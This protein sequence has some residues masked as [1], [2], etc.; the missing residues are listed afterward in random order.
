MNTNFLIEALKYLGEDVLLSKLSPV[1][2]VNQYQGGVLLRRG[3]FCRDLQVG[4]NFKIPIV[5]R[6]LTCTS[7]LETV[8][9]ANVNITTKDGK[10][11]TV[12]TSFEYHIHNPKQFLLDT[13]DAPSN[14]KDVAMGCIADCLID[15]E[16]DDISKRKTNNAIKKTLNQE[17]N[18]YGVTVT[19][20]WFTDVIT[21][22]VFTLF[23][24]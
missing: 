16:W 14:I 23:Q 3:K 11:I 9:I 1:F 17:L 19:R 22:K 15:C 21:T 7:T 4:W 10:A 8:L 12:S 20:F 6:F 13:N 5:D 24:Q 18:Q 2:F